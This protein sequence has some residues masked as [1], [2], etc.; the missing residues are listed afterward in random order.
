MD[1]DIVLTDDDPT[2]WGKCPNCTKTGTGVVTGNFYARA[3]SKKKWGKGNKTCPN[4]E[5]RLEIMYEVK[6]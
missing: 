5:T 4:C 1:R 2:I 6:K 3:F